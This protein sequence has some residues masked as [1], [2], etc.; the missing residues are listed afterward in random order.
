[1]TRL[2]NR[3]AVAVAAGALTLSAAMTAAVYAQNTNADP[4]PFNGPRMGRGGP[5]GPMGGPAE[6]LGMLRM[7]GDRIGLTDAQKDQL[8]AIADAHREEWK[9]LG[10][11]AR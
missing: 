4:R 5:G 2:T 9:T 1:M 11:R 3:I 8:K 7:L 10:D 6:A